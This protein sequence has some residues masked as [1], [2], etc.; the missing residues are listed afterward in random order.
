M[1]W[2]K[3]L[4]RG[5]LVEFAGHS[6]GVDAARP[7][8]PAIFRPFTFEPWST[9][10]SL[11]ELV[12]TPDPNLVTLSFNIDIYPSGSPWPPK[13]RCLKAPKLLGVEFSLSSSM[14]NHALAIA[15]SKS[16]FVKHSNL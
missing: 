6:T 9:S 7:K 4:A 16:H 11:T 14:S 3:V 8:D 1:V 5:A 2:H 10:K 13:I 12:T 15:K